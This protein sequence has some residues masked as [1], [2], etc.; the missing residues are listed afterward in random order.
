MSARRLISMVSVWLCALL[1]G[2][3]MWSTPALAQ[4]EHVF[5]KVF[6]SEG[7]GNGQ[8]VKPGVLAVNDATGD[9]YVADRG[10]E[11]VEVFNEKGEYVTQFNGSASPTGVFG[12]VGFGPTETAEGAIAVDNS[13]N[14][15]DQ[16]KGDVYVLDNVNNLIDKFSSTG[17]YLGQVTGTS[18]TSPFPGE[19]LEGT[20]LAGLSVDPNGNL[21]VQGERG[22][23]QIPIYEFNDAAPVNEYV[24]TARPQTRGRENSRGASASSQFGSIGIALDSED[25]IYVGLIIESAGASGIFPTKLS[26]TGEI[27]AETL[28]GNEELAS[29]MAVDFSSNDVYV[30]D[31]TSIVAYSPSQ[32]PIERFG[33]AQLTDSQGIA[34]DST[35]GMAYVS[36][37]SNGDIDVF[38]AFVVPDASTDSASNLAETSATLNGVVNPDDL[39]VTACVFEYRTEAEVS[40]GQS[41]PC[42]QTPA[43]IGTGSSSVAVSV[44]L[45]GLEPLTRY[46]FRLNVSNENGSNQGKD[47]TFVT[48]GPVQIS[49]ESVS[50]VSSGSAQ[51]GAQLNPDGANTTYRFEYGTSTSYGESIPVPAG[52]LSPL[53]SAV[54]VAVNVQNLLAETTYHV[55]LVATNLLGTAYGPDETFTTQAAGGAFALPDDR[56]WE[57]VSPPNKSGALIAAIGQN[58]NPGAIQSS[59]NGSAFTYEANQPVGSNPAGNPNPQAPIQ[60]LA[61]RDAG[62]WSSED[63]SPP[64]ST[65]LETHFGEEYDLFSADLSQALLV[66]LSESRL[67]PEATENT[68]YLRDNSSGSYLPLLTASNVPPGTTFGPLGSRV[69]WEKSEVIGATPNF[70]HVIIASPYALTKTATELRGDSSPNIYEWT[71]GQLQQVNMPPVGTTG[72]LIK[73]ALAGSQGKADKNAIS[74]D[75]SRVFFEAE[76]EHNGPLY[77]HD[78]LT[79][80]TVALPGHFQAANANGSLVFVLAEVAAN[81][82][83]LFAYDTVTE[84]TTDLSTDKNAGETASVQRNVVGVSENGSIVYFVATGVLAS[85]AEPGKPNLYVESE[86]GSTWSAPRLVAVLS[87][88]DRT[89]WGGTEGGVLESQ[90]S[91]V[92]ASGRYLTFMSDESLT[93]YD[94]RDANSGQPDEEVFLYDEATNHLTCASCNPTGARPDGILRPE[95]GDKF[96]VDEKDK[97]GGHWLAG[98]I[99]GWTPNV[100]S[101]QQTLAY[102]SRVLS[103]E[104]RLFFDSADALVPQ[105]TNGKEDVYEYEPEGV[106]SCA[107]AGG[108]V[109]LI[110]AGTSG[111]ESAFLDASGKGPSGEEGEDVFF[112]TASRLAPQDV[113]SSYD[114]YDAHVCSA[115]APCASLPVSPPPCTTGD[116]CKPAP[117]PQPAIFGAPASATFSGAG[118][119]ARQSKAVAASKKQQK[120]P[121]KKKRSRKSKRK[122]KRKSN[123]A[124]KLVR[125]GEALAR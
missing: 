42:K 16:S 47:Q 38:T 124:K 12:W 21:W 94:N 66:S 103:D 35:T 104:G 67:S 80:Q 60:V 121:A 62:G 117:S 48:P 24:A 85:G 26:K 59:T 46:H 1:G 17:A 120:L 8:L 100:A 37:A 88:V 111:E 105:D 76:A 28:A 70:S 13:T 109:S 34:V 20:G 93:G 64:N 95:G 73:N 82:N 125:Q 83:E 114:V 78:M 55:R 40:Y 106:G 63:L 89:D 77:M 68:P 113:D 2:L 3:L 91:R 72:P 92:S 90:T 79:E 98:N 71:E 49:E 123:Q 33:E 41:V 75:G 97:W 50:D 45:T 58:G 27:L 115:A 25:N 74:G 36:D 122:H 44:N 4:R 32:V 57:M 107:R 10:N 31:K 11:R 69:S 5:G 101:T 84:S 9:V 7:S 29:G 87:F 86:T 99:P 116:S 54:P 39:P 23:S 30:D 6:G 52:E 43:E 108:C 61:K 22:E 81:D 15:L 51:F 112:L 56:A 65:A 53:K 118:N 110:S 18:P 96:L 119:V 14:P 102:E 19:A